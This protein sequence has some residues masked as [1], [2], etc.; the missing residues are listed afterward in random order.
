MEQERRLASDLSGMGTVS[1]ASDMWP[2]VRDRIR[3]KSPIW[4]HAA[5]WAL[6]PHARR[7][8]AAVAAMLVI[9]VATFVGVTQHTAQV[10]QD[11]A[12]AHLVEMQTVNQV[13]AWTDDPL[14]DRSDR[15]QTLLGE[16]S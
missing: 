2:V 11:D 7:S 9:G 16:G 5:P 14:K 10:R 15:A 3:T 12:T 8:M 6:L 1:P 13:T 4:Q